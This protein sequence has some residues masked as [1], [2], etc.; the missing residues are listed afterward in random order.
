LDFNFDGN[1]LLGHY[2]LLKIYWL[3]FFGFPGL[4][5]VTPNP[6]TKNESEVKNIW[7]PFIF[8][9]FDCSYLFFDWQKGSEI[10]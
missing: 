4:A 10:P 9:C 3:N 7:D 6:T 2:T 5:Q 1:L 8:L